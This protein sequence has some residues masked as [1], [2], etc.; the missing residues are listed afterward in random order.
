M[1][2][3]SFRADERPIHYA[4]ACISVVALR[5]PRCKEN[6]QNLEN[7]RLAGGLTRTTR[8]GIVSGMGAGMLAIVAERIEKIKRGSGWGKVCVIVE[9][10]KVVCVE[11]S[12][13]EKVRDCK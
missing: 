9:R 12:D 2:T 10:G 7:W 8:Y 5:C 4:G 1:M 6:L 13:S 3:W 11:T